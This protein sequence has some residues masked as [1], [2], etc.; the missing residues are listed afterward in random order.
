MDH[1]W[2]TLA[3]FVTVVVGTAAAMQ[4]LGGEF[5]PELE[6]GNIWVQRSSP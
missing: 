3:F 5:M 4:Y 2:L 1:C 6:E